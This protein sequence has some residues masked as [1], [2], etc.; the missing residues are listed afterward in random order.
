MYIYS[1]RLS[2][3]Y[4]LRLSNI[5][6]KEEGGSSDAGDDDDDTTTPIIS[7]S[8]IIIIITESKEGIIKQP[9]GFENN[10]A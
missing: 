7:S 2:F 1:F 5:L 9:E 6:T 10:L 8:I 3:T 4:L